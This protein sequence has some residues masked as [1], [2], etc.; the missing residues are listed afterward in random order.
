MHH[1]VLAGGRR[2]ARAGS[3]CVSACPRGFRVF[4]VS[5][6]A[7]ASLCVCLLLCMCAS[8]CARA[9]LRV[10]SRICV[11]RVAQRSHRWL[12][13]KCLASRRSMTFCTTRHTWPHHVRSTHAI[14]NRSRPC[15]LRCAKRWRSSLSPG[16]ENNPTR[17]E[18]YDVKNCQKR[19]RRNLTVRP[20]HG[21]L[22]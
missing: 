17:P 13:C 2:P 20:V 12:L 7:S 16:G 10:W 5:V 11:R 1:C 19:S 4:C 9:G 3:G 18:S 22:V 21:H 15:H 6:S 14:I 8:V